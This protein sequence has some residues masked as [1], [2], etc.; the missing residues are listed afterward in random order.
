MGVKTKPSFSERPSADA[1]ILPFFEGNKPA[2]SG[3]GAIDLCGSSLKSGDFSGKC[4]EVLVH[5]TSSPKDKRVVLVGLGKEKDLTCEGVRKAYA[6]GLFAVKSKVKSLNVQIPKTKKDVTEAVCEGIL[7]S[8]YVFNE[9]KSKKD[10]APTDIVFLGGDTKVI[11]ETQTLCKSVSF[12][13]DLV[14]NNADEMTP[15]F[16]GNMAK[17]LA[18]KHPQVKAKVLSRKQIQEEHMGLLEAVSRGATEEPAFIIIEYKGAP[19]SKELYALIGKGITYDTGGLSLKPTSGMLDM[20]S[21]MGGAGA[22]LGTMHALCDLKLPINVVAVIASTENAIGPD[23]YKVGDVYFGRNGVSVEVT[24][25]DAEGRLVLADALSYVQDTYHPSKMIDLATLTGGAV[26]ALG[27]EVSALMCDDDQL[28]K[29]LIEAGEETF[30]RV[31]RLPL[32]EEYNRLLESKIADI[33]N[34]GDRKAS[35]IQGGIFLKRFVDSKTPWAHL[36]IAGTAFPDA[37]LKPYHPVQAT[38]YGVRLLIRYFRNE[39][40]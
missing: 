34:S 40:A 17:E 8:N 19:K 23:S 11:K 10:L 12:T 16:L 35:P 38:G 18:K 21:D 36:D 37:P 39:V 2:F 30:E 13:R 22:V 26:V 25:T 33:K 20:R 29:A 32:H 7:L 28:A 6:K 15:T 1:L 14:Y 24:N 9:H 3:S 31:W 4:A 5:Y 27:E